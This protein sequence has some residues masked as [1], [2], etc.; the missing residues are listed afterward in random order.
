MNHTLDRIVAYGACLLTV[1][2]LASLCSP[3]RAQSGGVLSR[4]QLE[5]LL[6]DSSKALENLAAV[7]NQ[8]VPSALKG[9]QD[10]HGHTYKDDL[11]NVLPPEVQT[12]LGALKT[13]AADNLRDGDLPG[14]QLTLVPL[15]RELAAGIERFKAIVDYW[16]GVAQAPASGFILRNSFLRTNG[17]EPATLSQ[18][19]EALEARFNQQIESRDFTQAMRVTRPQFLEASKRAGPEQL[20]QIVAG[21]D[22][23]ALRG[24]ASAAPTRKC[25]A[26]K[27]TSHTNVPAPRVR[28]FPLSIDYYPKDLLRQGLTGAP[29]VFVIVDANGCPERALVIGASGQTEMDVS[30]ARMAVDGVYLPAENDGKAIRSG[31]VFRVDFSGV[32]VR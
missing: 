31:F 28:E 7:R 3:T 14:A 29:L 32:P 19:A 22:S 8:S 21:L 11:Q 15:H 1:A 13:T 23:S 27:E 16:N 25:T 20:G 30:A 9:K 26:A 2:T 24:V 6:M 18:E 12:R 17:I 4:Q 10:L 5:A